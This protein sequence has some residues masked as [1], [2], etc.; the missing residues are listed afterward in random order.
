MIRQHVIGPT[1]TMLVLMICASFL[2]A[3]VGYGVLSVQPVRDP[4]N[5]AFAGNTIETST[6]TTIQ[7]VRD[8][9]NPH[10]TGATISATVPSVASSDFSDQ[11]YLRGAT[12][13]LR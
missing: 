9:E 2:L 7:P 12:H 13:G 4:Q 5:A 8:P 10:W 6:T 1:G 11:T 3:A